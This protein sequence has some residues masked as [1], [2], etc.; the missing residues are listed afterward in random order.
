M[1]KPTSLTILPPRHQRYSDS[2]HGL[3]DGVEYNSVE[4]LITNGQLTQGVVEFC[5]H[6][7]SSL[8]YI[9]IRQTYSQ[10]GAQLNHYL[11]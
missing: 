8:M 3:S 6:C 9:L 11:L 7:G 4:G 1:R 2:L 10:T 5:S